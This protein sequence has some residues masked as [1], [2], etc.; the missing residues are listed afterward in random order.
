MFSASIANQHIKSSIAFLALPN[1]LCQFSRFCQIAFAIRTK[2][3]FN[4]HASPPIFIY[5]K[6]YESVRFKSVY[7][8]RIELLN[9]SLQFNCSEIPNG[10]FLA[11]GDLLLERSLKFRIFQLSLCVKASNEKSFILR[12]RPAYCWKKKKTAEILPS[13]PIRIILSLYG[14]SL[15][16]PQSSFS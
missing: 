16:S 5:F 1:I 13:S 15:S 3:N 6:G 11:L 12:H 9:F 4:L 14:F 8:H 10:S 2:F 7:F